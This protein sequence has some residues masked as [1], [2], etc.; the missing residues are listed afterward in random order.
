M[1]RFLKCKACRLHQC[2][3]GKNCTWK[4]TAIMLRNIMWLKC[5]NEW[6]IKITAEWSKCEVVVLKPSQ[7]GYNHELWCCWRSAAPLSQSQYSLCVFNWVTWC[8][9][10]CILFMSSVVA[11]FH[12]VMVKDSQALLKHKHEY[13]LDLWLL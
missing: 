11:R 13:S 6:A 7:D 1:S 3:W 8:F 10:E 5:N 9:P 12:E 4:L 2:D